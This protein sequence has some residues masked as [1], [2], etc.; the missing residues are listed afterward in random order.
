MADLT[1]FA[2][3]VIVDWNSPFLGRC[4]AALDADSC[5]RTAVHVLTNDA[6]M[7]SRLP[8]FRRLDVRITVLE[9]NLG[10]A[11]ANNVAVRKC[12]SDWVILLNPDAFVRPGWHQA[13]AG[14]I[15]AADA[16][17]ACIG[18]LQLTG[19]DDSLIDGAGDSYHLSGIARRVRHGRPV[20]GLDV[21]AAA[22]SAFT[23]CA[24]AAAY[25]RS[26]FLQVGGF[27]ETFFCYME[28]VDL[29][30]RLALRG[31]RTVI[32]TDAV[33]HHVG[34]SSSGGPCSDF[35]LYHG[36]RNLVWTY[37]KNMPGI[38]LPLTLPLHFAA[39]AF[40]VLWH[41]L[42]GRG[43]VVLRAK[44]AAA[45]GLARAWRQRSDI[46]ETRTTS[47]WDL[48]RDMRVLPWG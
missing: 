4:L 36:H 39:N 20:S 29:G 45:R 16:S 46:Q 13:M 41:A 28:D 35:A 2:E 44:L 26:A 12:H 1:F 10:F 15:C 9:E 40:A 21:R 34:G 30:F 43:R 33:V 47:T 3:L 38:A 31:Q 22:N 5:G 17:T 18:S 8:V 25:R 6:D 14:A 11:R 7:L 23:A 37:F 48:L 42:N 19:P 27:D 24:A 32:A